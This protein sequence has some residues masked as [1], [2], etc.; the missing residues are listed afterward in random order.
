MRGSSPAGSGTVCARPGGG[1]VGGGG[2]TLCLSLSL[3]RHDAF[4]VNDK[5][6]TFLDERSVPSGGRGEKPIC[7][8][9]QC[10]FNFQPIFSGFLE[11][12]ISE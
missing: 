7:F 5:C 4:K 12:K 8:L 2:A 10:F 3:L 11:V 9:L 6:Q 1:G